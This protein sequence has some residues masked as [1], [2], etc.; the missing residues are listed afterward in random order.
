MKKLKNLFG[1]AYLA[2]IFIFLYA[3]IVTLIVYSYNE[4]RG[5]R[6]SPPAGMRS[7]SIPRRSGTR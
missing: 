6:A 4:G 3:P 7:C 2:L 5:R 1:S